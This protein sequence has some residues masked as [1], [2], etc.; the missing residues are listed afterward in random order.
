[1]K[2]LSANTMTPFIEAFNGDC[3]ITWY[4]PYNII[5]GVYHS[6]IREPLVAV[7][8]KCKAFQ[9]PIFHTAALVLGGDDGGLRSVQV[10]GVERVVVELN[11]KERAIS[12]AAELVGRLQVLPAQ[13][14]DGTRKDVGVR[15]RIERIRCVI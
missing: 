5:I 4:G 14:I 2:L 13:G 9:S 12:K 7:T 15:W 10:C 6:R 8:R 11:I 3:T 1:M